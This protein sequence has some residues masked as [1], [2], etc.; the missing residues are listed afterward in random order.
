LRAVERWRILSQ[1]GEQGRRGGSEVP[2][3]HDCT[4]PGTTPWP[5]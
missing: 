5:W 1:E 3:W 4:R 2:P